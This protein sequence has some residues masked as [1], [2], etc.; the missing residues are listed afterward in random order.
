MEYAEP[1]PVAQ[2]FIHV[3]LGQ[4]TANKEFGFILA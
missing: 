1:L 2:V 3:D 4:F